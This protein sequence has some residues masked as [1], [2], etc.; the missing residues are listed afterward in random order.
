MLNA[1]IKAVV[2]KVKP[3]CFHT[4]FE[5]EE[6]KYLLLI[7]DSG[8]VSRGF[9]DSRSFYESVFMK[10]I[11]PAFP[12][13]V[14]NKMG[15]YSVLINKDHNSGLKSL[16]TSIVKVKIKPLRDLY[17]HDVSV[18]LRESRIHG[19]SAQ[20][21]VLIRQYA[22]DKICN[23]VLTKLREIT[24]IIS[25][26]IGSDNIVLNANGQAPSY[27]IQPTNGAANE[28]D[29]HDDDTNPNWP[30]KTGNKSGGGRG[31]NPPSK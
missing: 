2:E 14:Q 25:K 23:K 22:T 21:N 15:A 5:Y 26:I 18:S 16:V 24:P 27:Y 30:S 8:D 13:E 28:G 19:M 9:R 20:I 11:Y 12:S 29:Y 1:S 7:D 6:N 10:K 4:F 31:N 17:E 3:G